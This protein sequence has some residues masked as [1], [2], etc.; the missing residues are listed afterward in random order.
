MADA[1]AICEPSGDHCGFE[2]G[3]GCVTT[4]SRAAVATVTTEMSAEPPS[5]GSLVTR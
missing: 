5:A 1:N 2:S 4:G 3:P